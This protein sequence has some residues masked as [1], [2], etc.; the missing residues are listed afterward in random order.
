MTKRKD[1]SKQ[2][3]DDSRRGE[4]HCDSCNVLVYEFLF[5]Y[6]FTHIMKCFIQTASGKRYRQKR[7][8]NSWSSSILTTRA[9]ILLLGMSYPSAPKAISNFKLRS[10]VLI[11]NLEPSVEQAIELVRRGILSTI[12]GRDYAR[13][14]ALEASNE[15]LAFTVSKEKGGPYEDKRHLDA[16]FNSRTF[17]REIVRQWG[18]GYLRDPIQFKQVS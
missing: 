6:N 18:V 9:N 13:I 1:P 3:C 12:D 10:N 2:L 16:D 11:H 8:P 15:L 7:D 17:I 4:F 14:K 5:V